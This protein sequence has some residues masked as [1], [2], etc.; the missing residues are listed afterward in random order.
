MD[1]TCATPSMLGIVLSRKSLL[2]SKLG[3]IDPPRFE[4]ENRE[5]P[6]G[7][8]SRVAS[9]LILYFLTSLMPSSI[10]LDRLNS[11][12]ARDGAPIA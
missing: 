3:K 7:L 9:S 10:I 11:L 1:E 8:A 4:E 6:L 5:T 2:D 12:R